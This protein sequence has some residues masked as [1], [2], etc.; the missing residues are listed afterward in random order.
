MQMTCRHLILN[1]RRVFWIIQ[2]SH[3]LYVNIFSNTNNLCRFEVGQLLFEFI[4][5]LMWIYKRCLLDY[6]LLL[7]SQ[8][9]NNCSVFNILVKKACVGEKVQSICAIRSCTNTFYGWSETVHKPIVSEV[10]SLALY[11][12]HTNG[13]WISHHMLLLCLMKLM[14]FQVLASFSRYLKNHLRFEL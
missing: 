4:L 10:I 14:K 12:K 7:Q 3:L 5:V 13:L 11:Y 1:F 8:C 6:L 2:L 9:I